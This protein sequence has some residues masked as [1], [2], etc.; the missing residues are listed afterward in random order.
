MA[1]TDPFGATTAPVAQ[2][3]VQQPVGTVDDIDLSALGIG[4]TAPASSSVT[5]EQIGAMS[6]LERARLYSDLGYNASMIKQQEALFG[7]AEE[8]NESLSNS[9]L[10]KN[11]FNEMGIDPFNENPEVSSRADLG[12]ASGVINSTLSGS[13]STEPNVLQNVVAG[14]SGEGASQSISARRQLV[15]KDWEKAYTSLKGGGQ[16]T[17][18]EGRTMANAISRLRDP[19]LTDEQFRTHAENLYKDLD[20]AAKLAE[21]NIRVNA[22]TGAQFMHDPSTGET[23]KVISFY[24]PNNG[25][26]IAQPLRSTDDVISIPAYVSRSQLSAIKAALPIGQKFTAEG[27][28][29]ENGQPRIFTKSVEFK[30]PN[31]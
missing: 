30:A 28:N 3:P 25:E 11:I 13:S 2:Q 17:E 21:N 23:Q 14:M 7:Q 4:N 19:S 10:L 29:D 26:L 16:I 9:L 15:A 12:A 27:I 31:Q 20:K 22:Q 18:F 5:P 6:E 1:F 8:R 24:N